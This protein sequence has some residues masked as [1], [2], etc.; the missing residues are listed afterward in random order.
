MA[1]K[2]PRSIVE[3]MECR[4]AVVA[5]SRTRSPVCD[6]VISGPIAAVYGAVRELLAALKHLDSNGATILV[7]VT[8]CK[9]VSISDIDLNLL[10]N[11]LIRALVS[12]RG[13]EQKTEKTKSE[14]EIEVALASATICFYDKNRKSQFSRAHKTVSS[15]PIYSKIVTGVFILVTNNWSK[16]QVKPVH[17]SRDTPS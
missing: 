15:G 10:L 11:D 9:I 8:L 2:K 4:G 13:S 5:C 7:E 1:V 16:F 6:L 17:R 14:S 3:I 12:A